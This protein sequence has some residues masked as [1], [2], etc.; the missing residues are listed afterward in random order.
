MNHPEYLHDAADF[1]Q[2]QTAELPL[3]GPD[4]AVLSATASYAVA[5]AKTSS[6][7][8]RGSGLSIF[9]VSEAWN[10]DS[11][12]APL[13]E[14]NTLQQV[15]IVGGWRSEAAMSI[16]VLASTASIILK[17]M[18]GHEEP[19]P[20][21]RRQQNVPQPSVDEGVPPRDRSKTNWEGHY[22]DIFKDY[23][24]STCSL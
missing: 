24:T 23:D 2:P 13:T 6:V 4:Y 1:M 5:L 3:C 10:P 18:I 8:S 11:P 19:N 17:G 7:I 12:G 16:S 20:S 14:I 21:E 22:S 9:S 15:V